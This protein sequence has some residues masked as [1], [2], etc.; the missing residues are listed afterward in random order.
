MTLL[1]MVVIVLVIIIQAIAKSKKI[2]LVFPIFFSLLFL[3]VIFLN[4]DFGTITTRYILFLVILW[5]LFIYKTYLINLN[6]V[7]K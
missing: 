4:G 3:T 6:N 5:S 2:L 1:S 7:P